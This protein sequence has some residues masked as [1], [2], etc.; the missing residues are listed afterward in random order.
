MEEA[1]RAHVRIN[2]LKQVTAALVM[3][4]PHPEKLAEVLEQV[5]AQ[6][7]LQHLSD[8]LV[9]E[10]VRRESSEFVQEFVELARFVANRSG[11]APAR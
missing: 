9:D 1:K 3:T 4:H 8:R 6:V 7:K 10:E 2:A 5:S 11:S